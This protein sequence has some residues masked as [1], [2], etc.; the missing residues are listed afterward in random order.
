[1]GGNLG[2]SLLGMLA[3]LDSLDINYYTKHIIST[4]TRRETTT[5]IDLVKW[6]AGI[7]II[8]CITI[9]FINILL[10]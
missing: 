10:H 7:S 6:K 2:W 9:F 8:E 4:C 1:M 5:A 3:R